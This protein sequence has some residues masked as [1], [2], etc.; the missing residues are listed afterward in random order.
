MIRFSRCLALLLVCAL[1]GAGETIA[2]DRTTEPE[3]SSKPE[4]TCFRVRDTRGFSAIDDRF[5]YVKSVRDQHYLLTLDN[6]CYGL[7]YS[8]K[9]AIAN[10]ID[11]VCSNDRAVLTYRDFNRLHRCEILDVEAV[12]SLDEAEELVT[13]RT[14]PRPKKNKKNGA[15]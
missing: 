3:D 14:T 2:S 13:S 8:I 7:E 9:I 15:D 1:V 6:R 5:V 4:K 10:E 11:R 12:E